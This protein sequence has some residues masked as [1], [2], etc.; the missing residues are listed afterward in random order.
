[1]KFTIKIAA[2]S[3]ILFFVSVITMKSPEV[4][5]EKQK[6]LYQAIN[7]ANVAEV[8]NLL[9]AGYD[10]NFGVTTPLQYTLALLKSTEIDFQQEAQRIPV[11]LKWSELDSKISNLY[12]I[13]KLLLS[14]GA[15]PNTIQGQMPLLLDLLLKPDYRA[16]EIIV[17]LIKDPQTTINAKSISGDTIL[18]IIA[19]NLNK[20]HDLVPI[21]L[22]R[23]DLKVNTTNPQ[24]ETALIIAVKNNPVGAA[25]EFAQ[26][27]LQKPS[28]KI[29]ATDKWGKT[30]LDFAKGKHL[31]NLLRSQGAKKGNELAGKETPK[32][33]YGAGFKVPEYG[34]YQ[35]KPQEASPFAQP[36]FGVPPSGYTPYTGYPRGSQFPPPPFSQ[37]YKPFAGLQPVFGA[38]PMP[39]PAPAKSIDEKLTDA[40]NVG[41]LE[42]VKRLLSLGA[43]PNAKDQ[44]GL[45]TLYIATTRGHLSL[46]QV[47]LAEKN[48]NPNL[49]TSKSHETALMTAAFFHRIPILKELL[50]DARVIAGINLKSKFGLNALDYATKNKYLPTYAVVEQLLKEKGAQSG[51]TQEQ[52]RIRPSIKPQFESAIYRLLD[53][54]PTATPRQILGVKSDASPEEIKKAWRALSLKWH[55]DRNPDPNAKEVFKLITWAYETLTA[56]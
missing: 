37:P 23:K 25:Q 7:Q 27:I 33:Q 44:S 8:K 34:S 16:K 26:N 13:I 9:D 17:Q 43:N 12:T 38:A 39:P 42:E 24:G 1:M 36:K 5:I 48:L 46:V 35:S 11:S 54:E 30:A 3:S 49:G 28:L 10:L 19:Q 53:V 41:N 20:F 45:P 4:P 21:L 52:P 14:H 22:E 56:Q 40:T 31:P 55:P 15:N 2:L 51:I 6:I 32:P 50:N 18:T 47:L 29:N